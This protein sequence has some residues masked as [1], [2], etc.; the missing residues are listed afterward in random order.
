MG[1]WIIILIVSLSSSLV[2]IIYLTATVT[3]FPF[4]EKLAKGK[5]WAKILISLGLVLATFLVLMK[6]F[7]MTNAIVIFLGAF[8]IRM[9]LGIIGGIIKKI[10][11]KPFRFYWQGWGALVL[12]IL[13]FFV[14]Y[15]I[16]HHVVATQYNLTTDKE[17][18]DLRVAMFADSHMGTTFDAEGFAGNMNKLMEY[19]PD[20]VLIV[21]DY[22]DDSTS[23]EDMI[24]ATEVLGTLNPKYGVWY[25]IGN[26]DRGYNRAED[27][28]FD[29]RE[30]VKA[31]MDNSVGILVDECVLIDDR[32]YLVGREDAYYSDRD[33]ISKLTADL[34][35]DI[36]SIVMD[37]QPTDYANEAAAG[38]D[39]V[40]SGHT[41]GGQ[42]FP[43]N[44][45]GDWFGINDRTYGYEK[46]DNT[47]FIV[48]SGISSWEIPFKTG[49]KSEF[50][51]IDI[52]GP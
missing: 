31:L 39:L 38:V 48:T 34:D 20:I 15:Y 32:F 51:I 19:N 42:L 28:A 2:G 17:V 30:L 21:G 9:I 24:K 46:R 4:I 10:R 11:K 49:T 45:V 36:Y 13:Y 6:V 23:K 27:K 26:H 12:L 3:K 50:V 1:V 44:H 14:A 52:K 37:H 29:E 47:E 16:A 35:K 25:A 40:L 8:L 18:G 41:H 22:V 43:I 7:S 5:K 33:N